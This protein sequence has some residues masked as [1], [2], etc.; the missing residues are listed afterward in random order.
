MDR[1]YLADWNFQRQPET[2][3]IGVMI[4][5]YFLLCVYF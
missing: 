4:T 2:D 3:A 5:E 1:E